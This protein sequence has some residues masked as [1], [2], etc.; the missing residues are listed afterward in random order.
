MSTELQQK[1]G[2]ARKA[3]REV[4]L[5]HLDEVIEVAKMQAA[6]EAF[7][8]PRKQQAQESAFYLGD[9]WT[10][11][12]SDRIDRLRYDP[13]MF[14][15]TSY[16]DRRYGRFVPV[17][18]T[19]QELNILRM[20]SRILANTNNYAQ[21]FLANLTRYV[22]GTGFTYEPR[23]KRDP[24]T[25]TSLDPSDYFADLCKDVWEDFQERNSWY[26]DDRPGLEEEFFQRWPV[27]GEAFLMLFCDP[28]TGLTTAREIEPEQVTQPPG[29]DYQTSAFGILNPKDDTQKPEAAWVF[30][31]DHASDGSYYPFIATDPAHF[32]VEDNPYARLLHFRR[33]TP[34]TV[35]RGCPDFVFDTYDTFLA[36]AKLRRNLGQGAAVQAAYAIVREHEAIDAVDV[37]NMADALAD[38][39]RVNPLNG[40]LERFRRADSGTYDVPQGMKYVDPPSGKNSAGHIE[41]LNSALL[42]SAAAKWGSPPWMV[43]SKQETGGM[44]SG[45]NADIAQSPWIRAVESAQA[46]LKQAF[47]KIYWQVIRFYVEAKGGV[48]GRS[49][50]DIKRLVECHCEPRVAVVQRDKDKQAATDLALMQAKIKSPQQ[51]RAELGIDSD[52]ADEQIRE[53]EEEHGPIDQPPGGNLGGPGPGKPGANGQQG[54]KPQQAAEE[55]DVIDLGTVQEGIDEDDLTLEADDVEE[56]YDPGEARDMRGRW[57]HGGDSHGR[58]SG[59]AKQAGSAPTDRRPNPANPRLSHARAVLGHLKAWASSKVNH[60]QKGTPALNVW[61]AAKEDGMDKATFISVLKVL[62][63]HGVIDL[64][65]KDGIV[66]HIRPGKNHGTDLASL[67]GKTIGKAHESFD[68]ARHP[69]GE[70]GRWARLQSKVERLRQELAAHNAAEPPDFHEEPPDHP[71]E[72]AEKPPEHPLHPDDD[73]TRDARPE[74]PSK[75]DF[76]GPD[77]FNAAHREWRDE[78]AAWEENYGKATAEYERA[79]QAHPNAVQAYQDRKAGH[80]ERLKA[81]GKENE[82]R[83]RAHE[84]LLD[85]WQARKERLE[86]KLDEAEQE[87]DEAGPAKEG[88]DVQ[89]AFEPSH[90]GG[91]SGHWIRFNGGRFFVSASGQ[92][93]TGDHKGKHIGEAGDRGAERHF[94]G[95]RA[96]HHRKLE[97]VAREHR[98]LSVE[99]SPVS[100]VRGHAKSEAYHRGE[101]ERHEKLAQPSEVEKAFGH[102][103]SESPFARMKA[104]TPPTAQAM[105]SAPKRS[106]KDVGDAPPPAPLP[107]ALKA[108]RKTLDLGKKEPVGHGGPYPDYITQGRTREPEAPVRHEADPPRTEREWYERTYGKKAK[109]GA[110]SVV[111]RMRSYAAQE[112]WDPSS[113]AWVELTR[114]L[115]GA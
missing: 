14:S 112:D 29:G 88:D 16:Y 33:N 67:V 21:A 108:P 6:S 44:T 54:P 17:F 102:K 111:A 49:F 73:L 7:R 69:R 39:Q 42:I 72:F 107:E 20:A 36:A 90:F 115:A 46:A 96:K 60:P 3:A 99:R 32:A 64:E 70:H 113:A 71:G 89:E 8:S 76:D 41:I 30:F 78:H 45:Q 22:V 58:A 28:D 87:L 48:K 2:D 83:E 27:D 77:D 43:G 35:K 19:E 5:A 93:M 63:A 75:E 18:Q 24:A 11:F 91:V 104:G 97:A 94:H 26:G 4:R 25:R 59:G 9:T 47:L 50:E 82:R 1:W 80:G 79:A 106:A 101:A 74:E 68:E 55:D 98:L 53:W 61:R 12:W 84:R 51:V 86:D 34:R 13:Y 95:E 52:E 40:Q 65:V 15:V 66:T 57:T 31:T 92:I 100:H 38:F 23:T 56:G 37:S 85:R 114:E 81:W 62:R 109:E 110:P 10:S 105:P 103:F